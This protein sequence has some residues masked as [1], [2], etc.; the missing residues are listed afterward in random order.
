M[1]ANVGWARCSPEVI[2]LFHLYDFASCE[3][4]DGR[5]AKDRNPSNG[6]QV[7]VD[8]GE[9]DPHVVSRR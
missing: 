9:V 3:Q 4:D 6:L 5:D 8:F 1:S 2:G 7:R